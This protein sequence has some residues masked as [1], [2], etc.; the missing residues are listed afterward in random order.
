[1]KV[2][3]TPWRLAP[4]LLAGALLTAALPASAQPHAPPSAAPAAPPAVSA[5]APAA[6]APPPVPAASAAAMH[7]AA[8]SGSA[9]AEGHGAA[10]VRG[11]PVRIHERQVFEVLAARAGRTAEERAAAAGHVLERLVEEGEEPEVGVQ[12]D[13]DLAVVYGG[14]GKASI[15]QLGPEDA[16]AAG[17]TSAAICADGVAARVK[18]ALHAEHQRSAIATTVFAFSLLV[19]WGSS[20]SCWSARWGS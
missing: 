9:S 13:G 14:K 16:A 10:E 15:I 7:R 20:P 1:V 2:R 17:K 6:P 19:F 11:T 12:E 18:D 8:P 3:P 5:S 4:A